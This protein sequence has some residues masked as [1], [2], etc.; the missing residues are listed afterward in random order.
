MFSFFYLL[1]F[2][3][4]HLSI[5]TCIPFSDDF[6]S[7]EPFLSSFDSS[8]NDGSSPSNKLAL[9]PTTPYAE[10][11]PQEEFTNFNTDLIAEGPPSTLDQER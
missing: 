4:I 3:L 8:F 7:T 1:L 9:A 11:A 10:T 2:P 5:A 6:F